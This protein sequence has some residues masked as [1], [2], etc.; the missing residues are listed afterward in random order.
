MHGLEE[1]GAFTGPSVVETD[2]WST[3]EKV[4]RLSL[5]FRIHHFLLL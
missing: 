3:R 1:V 5:M 2:S 4:N